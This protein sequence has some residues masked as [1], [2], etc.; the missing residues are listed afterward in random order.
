M[1]KAQRVRSVPRFQD[2][3][4]YNIYCSLLGS[5]MTTMDVKNASV[6]YIE[7]HICLGLYLYRTLLTSCPRQNRLHN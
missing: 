2:M 3:I 7:E 4:V 1:T 5:S 6:L